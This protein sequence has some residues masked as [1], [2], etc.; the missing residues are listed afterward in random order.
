MTFLFNIYLLIYLAAPGLSCGM[1]ALV[2][3]PGIEPRPLH[4][5]HGVLTTGPPGKS[6][7]R[8]SIIVFCYC[9]V[10]LYLVEVNGLQVE[11]LDL[12][13]FSA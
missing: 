12:V 5:E 9:P 8:L 6:G 2:P 1:W 7:G 13:N 4:W 10:T 11:F 3:Q